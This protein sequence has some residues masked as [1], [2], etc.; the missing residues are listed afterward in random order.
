MIG[1]GCPSG[2][3]VLLV[4]AGML[5]TLAW[6]RGPE[7]DEQYTLFLTAGLPR[8]TWPDHPFPAAAALALQ[9]GRWDPLGLAGALRTTDVHPPLYFWLAAAWR[10]LF[11]DALFVLRLAS[12]ACSLAALGLVARIGSSLG[13][14]AGLAVL[15]TL[16]CYGF[17]YPGVVARGFAPAQALLLG[18]VAVLIGAV[19]PRLRAP[20]RGA[21][22]GAL[23]GAAV[24]TNY[25]ALFVAVAAIG[26][27]MLRLLATRSRPL[28]A[29][30]RRITLGLVAGFIPGLALAGW[31]FLAQRDS[32]PDQF[33]P[34]GWRGALDRLARAEGGALFGGLPLYVP[35]PLDTGL[36]AALGAII[37][38]SAALVVLRWR[39][40]ASPWLRALL[41]A[42]AAAPP[43]GLLLLGRIF[44]TSPIELRYL[45]FATPWMALLLAGAIGSLSRRP[46]A[47]IGGVVL[48]LQALALAGMGLAD[49]TMQ[50]AKASARALAAL[51]PPPLILV[52]FGNDGV[53]LVAA[54]ARGLPP[55]RRLLVIRRDEP[56]IRLH[57]RLAAA[58]AR[59]VAIAWMEQDRESRATLAHVRPF[60]AAPCWR[61]R[62]HR[63]TLAVFDWVCDGE[64]HVL[65][66]VHAGEGPGPGGHDPPAPWRIRPAAADAARQSADPCDV[67][68]GGARPG[69]PLHGDLPGP[70]GLRLLPQTAGDAGP[71]ALR[72][73]RDGAGHGGGDGAFRP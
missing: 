32:R 55:D 66:G 21:L 45:S 60:F 56:D 44:Q 42:L 70:A 26:W 50:P 63:S 53:G 18:A 1:P 62:P 43:A 30:A 14:R 39:Q 4:A 46:A 36:A 35:S 33:A 59:S 69:T 6:L 61:Q 38:G 9:A 37:L 25:L 5:T 17:A 48:G 57:A 65:R 31:F 67:A 12:V 10:V 73:A 27:Q 54:L 72:Q 22:A 20:R 40:F 23:F 64:A 41:A 2:C 13:L 47:A 71:C 51:Q 68:Q 11:G 16:G 7:Y 24:S 34:F 29:E 58:R 3:G 28:R 19:L 8:P 15:L 49:A 52:P